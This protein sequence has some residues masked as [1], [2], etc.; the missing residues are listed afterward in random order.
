M[1]GPW[2]EFHPDS[3]GYI[4]RRLKDGEPVSKAQLVRVFEANPGFNWQGPIFEMLC[5]IMQGTLKQKPGPKE[6]EDWALWQCINACVELEYDDIV[7]ARTRSGQPRQR[8]DLS[9]M[10]EAYENTARAFRLGAG[11]SLANQL[12]SRKLR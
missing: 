2:Y 4:E 7:A 8:Y 5:Q 6:R 11:R 3:A 12:S 10:E 1:Q 9:P